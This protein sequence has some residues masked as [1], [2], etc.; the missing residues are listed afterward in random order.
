MTVS[1]VIAAYDEAPVIGEV[2]RRALAALPGAEVVV[3][4]DGSRDGTDAAASNAGAVVVRLHQNHGK[5]HAVRRGI[6]RAGGEVIVL[7]DG[8]GQDDPADIPVLLAAL[9]GAD[10]VIGSR[11]V[12]RLGPGAITPVN[13]AGNRFLTAVLNLLY[14]V[15]LTDTQ[16]GFKALR[17][18]LALDLDL[19]AGRYDI[20][21]DL[22][23]GVLQRGGRVVEV[24]VGREARP[25]GQ[26]R[27]NRV[28]D[29]TRILGRI[30][31]K[32][33]RRPAPAEARRARSGSRAS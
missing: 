27:F 14:G 32:R 2:V 29:G 11:F 19:T 6:A 23:L 9:E 15:R 3:A 18:S 28:L 10:L 25:H 16:A 30:L 5:G 12:G 22:L 4:D 13:Y 1:V 20:E 31:L 24:P 17:R 33:L 8:D 21:V 26:S 7:L